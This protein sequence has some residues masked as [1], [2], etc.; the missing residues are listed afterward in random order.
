MVSLLI[1]FLFSIK[2]LKTNFSVDAGKHGVVPSKFNLL[3]VSYV[4]D[5]SDVPLSS[6]DTD[7]EIEL[8]PSVGY[9]S[10]YSESTSS[11]CSESEVPNCM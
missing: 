10:D 9:S 4:A 2:Y 6:S 1:S 11:S 7:N 3:S 8:T 5:F